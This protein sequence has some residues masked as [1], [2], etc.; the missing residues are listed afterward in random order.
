MLG[1]SGASGRTVAAPRPGQ[2]MPQLGAARFLM[3][4]QQCEFQLTGILEGLGRDPWTVEQ[5]KRPLRCTGTALGVAIGLLEVRLQ[6]YK[7]GLRFLTF[8]YRL[9]SLIP[10]R[11]LCSS[12]VERLPKVLEWWSAMN[13]RS[14]YVLTTISIAMVPSTTSGPSR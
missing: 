3:P 13:S 12:L 10:E 6:S 14:P 8:H 4:A 2:P 7:R 5:D 1:L 9:L 11:G